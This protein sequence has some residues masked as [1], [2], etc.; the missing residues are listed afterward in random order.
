MSTTSPTKPGGP[1]RIVDPQTIDALTAV[2]NG[3]VLTPSTDGYETAR[4]VWNGMI[5]K[6]PALIVRC[7]GRSDVVHAV[8]FARQ[9]DLLISIRGGAH[10]AAGHGT[11]DGGIVID[12]SPMKGVRVDPRSKIAHA[13]AG[14][15]WSEFDAETQVFGLATTG[16][17]VSNTGI[18]G[19]TLGGGL[20]WLM[21]KHGLTCDNVLSFDIVNAEGDVITASPESHPD[22]YWALRGGG[23]NFGIVTSF[24]FQLHE[25]SQVIGGSIVYPMSAAR[26]MLRFYRDIAADPPDELE[27]NAGLSTTPDGDPVCALMLGYNGD[28]AHGEDLIRPLREFGNPLLDSARPRSYGARQHLMDEMV[29]YGPRRYWKSGLVREIT[30]DLIDVLVDRGSRLI[31]PL[32]RVPMFNFHG[33]AARV[34]PGDTAFV[35]RAHQWDLGIVSQWLDPAEDD[36]QVAWTREFWS[37]LEPFAGNIVYINHVA[38]DEP[39]RV[40]TAFGDNFERLRQIK[41]KYDPTNAFR[42]NHNIPV[43]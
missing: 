35:H 38:G 12:L 22:L 18:S 11:C 25:I 15:T 32:T 36:R 41:A 2:I 5:D 43:S 10:S 26:D 23:G 40:R 21:G 37:E 4:R 7:S 19:L 17:T 24:E 33:A 20:G 39:D 13:Q 1:P 9:H 28:I 30:D 16:G 42:L 29:P 8:R 34:D 6:H 27:I 14:L 3:T 31:S